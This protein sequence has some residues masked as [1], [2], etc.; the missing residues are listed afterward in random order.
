MSLREEYLDILEHGAGF[1]ALCETLSEAI[2]EP[3]ALI[4]PTMSVIGHSKDY[5]ADVLMDLSLV[6]EIY[7]SEENRQYAEPFHDNLMKRNAFIDIYPYLRY[8]HLNCGCF[9][10]GN[11]LA[12][13]DIPIV[14]RSEHPAA[15]TMAEEAASVFT[16][17]ILINKGAPIN[18]V[19]SMEA[20]MSA[21]LREQISPDTPGLFSYRHLPDGI[22]TW[23]TIW[24][25]PKDSDTLQRALRTLYAFC[26]RQSRIWCTDW[27]EG[28]S[29]LSD[30]DAIKRV[31]SLQ[32]KL[33]DT[34]F[35]Q[36]RPFSSLSEY[37]SVTRRLQDV[38]ALSKQINDTSILIHED[39]YKI[40]AV[41][42]SAAQKLPLET[43]STHLISEIQEYDR[44]HN[45]D[46]IP[47]LRMYLLNH[48]D[49]GIVASK[50]HIHRN[51]ATYRL[52]QI[53]NLFS[54]DLSD[55]A[56]IT[57]LYL[58]LFISLIDGL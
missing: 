17:A 11:L 49:I 24:I 6:S 36:S 46:F 55:C 8:K 58:S 51:T 19:D 4:L 22:K 12:V 43:R 7:F 54:I 40:P 50:M 10:H 26:S 2:H 25:Q 31:L 15:L 44:T 38:F 45:N 32:E 3:V 37:P 47:T 48:M 52:Q 23:Q 18:T 42:L 53:E 27:M 28:I 5:S 41:F 35:I 13:I 30:A 1:T 57:E 9:W 56:V 20:H 21:L 14:S 16:T 39:I 33:P 29:V 34:T